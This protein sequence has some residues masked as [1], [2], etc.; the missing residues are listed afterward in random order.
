MNKINALFKIIL[1]NVAV[2]GSLCFGA[3]GVDQS[4]L[5]GLRYGPNLSWGGMVNTP[6]VWGQWVPQAT[7]GMRYTWLEPLGALGYG[8]PLGFASAYLR[9]DASVEVSPFYGGYRAGLGLRPFRIN[10]QIEFNFVYESYFYFKSNLEMVN[11]DVKGK[12]YIAETW[13][14]DYILDNVGRSSD[15]DYAQLFDMS[16]DFSYALPHGGVIGVGAHYVLSDISTD[17]EGKSY[18]YERNIPVFSRDYIVELQT[19]GRF[20]INDLVSLVYEGM[21]LKTGLLRSGGNVKKESL[22]Y[23]MMLL[24]THFSWQDGLRNFVVK[25][26]MWSRNKKRFYNGS[27]AQ[28]LLIQLEYK[29]YFSFPFHSNFT[30]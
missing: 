21:Y 17:F 6:F 11:A 28:Q 24:G 1:L 5:V 3:M 23:R 7:V 10:P 20:P 22:S 12:G 30:K 18:D 25:A 8:Q 4:N 26:G 13:N 9:M 15:F 29:G 27:F 19:F 16:I 2:L 14:S